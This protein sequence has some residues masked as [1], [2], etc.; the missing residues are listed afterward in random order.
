VRVCVCVCVCVCAQGACGREGCAGARCMRTSFPEPSRVWQPAPADQIEPGAP[1]A[2]I[3]ASQ[4]PPHVSPRPEQPWRAGWEGPRLKA[5][6]APSPPTPPERIGVPRGGGWPPPEVGG[7]VSDP[8]VR[9]SLSGWG[10]HGR[11]PRPGACRERAHSRV[12]C[13]LRVVGSAHP[14]T[15][16]HVRMGGGT[17]GTP[18]QGCAEGGPASSPPT[19]TG[20]AVCMWARPTRGNS[21]QRPRL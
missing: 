20:C 12:R 21:L 14:R 18:G 19:H 17:V 1:W 9:E 2:L 6:T 15:F 3:H 16:L 13:A 7:S 5:A 11:G 4:P 8:R 10:G